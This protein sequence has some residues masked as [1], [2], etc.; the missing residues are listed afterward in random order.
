MQAL[1]VQASSLTADQ[2]ERQV[3]GL[4]M[5]YPG[6]GK[7]VGLPLLQ[8][9]DFYAMPHRLIYAAIVGI[10]NAGAVPEQVAVVQL[11]REA[12]QLEGVGGVANVAR[13]T[14]Q[15]MSPAN[16]EQ[17]CRTLNAFRTKR[18]LLA[19]AHGIL[20]SL[21]RE[22]DVFD[23]LS[24]GE[25]AFTT[26]NQ[27]FTQ[28]RLRTLRDA[29]LESVNMLIDRL[30]NP[31]RARVQ[32]GLS[33]LDRAVGGLEPGDV[34][35]YAARSG[36]GKTDFLV[37]FA[38]HNGLVQKIPGVIF[39]LEMTAVQMALR[40]S[41]YPSGVPASVARDGITSEQIWKLSDTVENEMGGS[42]LVVLNDVPGISVAAMRAAMLQAKA[43]FPEL[44]WM[45]VD[46]LQLI[47]G[48][49]G[50]TAE[51][52]IKAASI[53]LK[54][55][56]KELG[57]VVVELLQLGRE[58]DKRLPLPVP[59]VSDIRGSAQVEMDADMIILPW[60]PSY[61]DKDCDSEG[62]PLPDYMVDEYVEFIIAKNRHKA[63]SIAAA[64]YHAGESRFSC[65]EPLEPSEQGRLPYADD[66][67]PVPF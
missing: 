6:E 19:H 67:G 13:L 10:T 22:E 56:A 52:A 66:N 28:T 49:K 41:A 37:Q 27:S 2:I 59:T 12:H 1:E 47:K 51:E 32:L 17:Y 53:A 50:T 65:W 4:L 5:K 16:I 30:N 18:E 31:K 11:L 23:V 57:I 42:E 55:I 14:Y 26:I 60:R 29:G 33:V 62:V 21:E 24:A 35:G 48:L 36:I 44:G 34:I 7:A 3:L 46:Y 63:P 25:K 20:R 54:E 39:S 43:K 58:V 8:Q 45:V 9:N 61:Y 38:R 15:D 40:F 64:K